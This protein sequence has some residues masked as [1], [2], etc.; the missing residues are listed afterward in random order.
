MAHVTQSDIARKLN[1]TRIT[2]SK[3]LRGHPDI[4]PG[5]KKRVLLAAE[6]LG[7]TPN[8]VARNLTSK[9][10]L[11]LGLVLPDL[12]NSFF[13]YAADSII[14]AAA[15][16]NYNVV[17][18]VSREDQRNEGLNIQRLVGMRVDGLIVCASQ[19][20]HDTGSFERLKDLDIPLVFFDRLVEGLECDSVT[21]D[22]QNGALVAMEAIFNEGYSRI[23]HIAGYASTSVGRNRQCGYRRALETNGLEVNS[24]WIIEG[25]FE[26]EDGYKAF[27]ELYRS[28]SL[29]EVILAV[30]DRAALGVYRGAREV[31]LN[32]P[33]DI[34]VVAFGFNDT[35]QALTPALSVINQDPRRLGKVAADLL[36]AKLDRHQTAVQ[37]VRLEEEFL[38]NDSLRRKTHAQ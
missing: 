6:G 33:D 28:H 4:S 29:P 32:I 2:V 25:G 31:H 9:R 16:Q 15:E 17:V 38:W 12:E 18:T 11:T 34:G 14:D 30:N 22:D 26:V 19:H 7:Y 24:A 13:A 27:M 23:A 3:A 36:I 5:M 37:Q 20:T 1:V 8:L 10:T 35:A 21:F